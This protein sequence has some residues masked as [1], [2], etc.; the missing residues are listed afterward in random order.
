MNCRDFFNQAADG[1]DELIT[2]DSVSRLK[3]II[4]GLGINKGST[5]LDV[6]SGTGILLPLLQQIMKREGRITAI[7]ISEKMLH[8]AMTKRFDHIVDHIQADVHALP[9]TKEIFDFAICYSCFP[10]FEDKAAALKE[11]AQVLKKRGLIAIVHTASREEINEFH[12]NAGSVVRDH[13]IP[14]G[15]DLHQM[16]QQAGFVQIEIR[17][18]HDSYLTTA[19]KG[20]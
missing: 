8:K 16:L 5:V 13:T 19:R 20:G 4:S 15:K 12:Y 18:S 6:G 11:L 7:D 9:L 3:Q 17:D 10:H 1:W 14:E 2:Q